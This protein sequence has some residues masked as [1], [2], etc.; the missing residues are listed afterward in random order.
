MKT[1][2]FVIFLIL[3]VS[4]LPFGYSAFIDDSEIL[5]KGYFLLKNEKMLIFEFRG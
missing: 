5:E 2:F 3:F 4:M 1:T